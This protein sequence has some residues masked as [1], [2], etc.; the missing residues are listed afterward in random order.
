MARRASGGD[1]PWAEWYRQGYCYHSPVRHYKTETLVRK[2]REGVKSA[3]QQAAIAFELS[4]RDP[5]L[6]LSEV[7]AT[8]DALGDARPNKTLILSLHHVADVD[9]ARELHRGFAGHVQ[10][11]ESAFDPD[12]LHLNAF[13][14]ILDDFIDALPQMDSANAERQL[15]R[16]GFLAGPV[17][18]PIVDAKDGQHDP[19]SASRYDALMVKFLTAIYA[20]PQTVS[21]RPMLAEH[22]R[23]TYKA[24]AYRFLL[25]RWAEGQATAIDAFAAVARLDDRGALAHLGAARFDALVSAFLAEI[26]GPPQRFEKSA[27]ENAWLPR[28]ASELS[29]EHAR[30]I[31][32]A[33]LANDRHRDLHEATAQML[34]DA[35]LAPPAAPPQPVA[36]DLGKVERALA[37]TSILHPAA[38]SQTSR[39]WRA[40]RRIPIARSRSRISS[41]SRAAIARPT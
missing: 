41:T 7:R 36:P 32:D 24:D 28:S 25:D 19:T 18:N 31:G 17:T 9:T 16:L 26:A 11:K 2:W 39:M 8:L 37:H 22:L 3:N 21:L 14:A 5:A 38:L 30:A 29:P 12:A 27:F 23:K 33:F 1:D 13:A 40:I 15:L 6:A 20:A 10:I 4:F 35:G 34:K